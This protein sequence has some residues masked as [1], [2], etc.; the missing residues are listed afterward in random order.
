M[1]I[2]LKKY[3]LP[4]PR[5]TSYPTVPYWNHDGF[6]INGY[7]KTLQVAFWESSK[8]IS[9]YIH[10][11]YCE[12]LCTY[13]ACNTRIT[14]NH[15]VEGPYIDH[16]LKEWGMY[17]HH[18]PER[19]LIKE[20]HLG[21]G[22]PTF[23]SPENL[24]VLLS[25]IINSARVAGDFTMSFEGHPAN[26]TYDHLIMFSHL[27]FTRLSLGI[28]DFDE[29]VQRLINRHQTFE[30]VE[31][32]TQIA[33][34]LGYDSINYDMVYGLPGQTMDSLNKTLDAV[35]MLRPERIAFYSYAHVPKLKPAQKSFESDLPSAADKYRF[36]V[37]G[38]ERFLQMEY[39][40]VGMDHFVQPG[41][42]LLESQAEGNLHRN[43]MGYTAHKSKLLIGLG[44]SAISD[45][46]TGFAQN[47]KSINSYFKKLDND[48]LPILKGHINTSH[49]LFIRK[50]ILNLMCKFETNWTEDDLL[51]YG[52]DFN[53]QLLEGMREDGLILFNEKGI[54][55]LEGGKEVIRV[56]CSALDVSLSVSGKSPNFSRSV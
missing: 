27:G 46:W 8:E 48:E 18:L 44:V 30:Q 31:E 36:K 5:Y 51:L 50:H 52:L 24:E 41:D 34:G 53:Y 43:F 16:L 55:V 10:L 40:E 15:Q 20:I 29:K 56:V 9:L 23:F 54:R 12:S 6:S 4:V 42:E 35:E 7:L 47:D 39:V 14:K 32:I 3:D 26:T 25:G 49:D 37:I 22:T 45:T 1:M 33:R 19:P 17:L 2:D 13:C 28:Q 21:G 38:K 11:P